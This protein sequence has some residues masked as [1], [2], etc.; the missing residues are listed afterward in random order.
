MIPMY[1]AKENSPATTLAV[2]ISSS[3]TTIRLVN[4]SV[5]PQAPNIFTISPGSDDS[6]TVRY[7]NNPMNNV[8]TVE[9]GFQGTAR[10]WNAGED[11]C[12]VYTAY[13]HDAFIQNIMSL[14]T[15][16]DDTISNITRSGRYISSL[17]KGNKT[18]TFHRDSS[19]KI[20]SWEVSE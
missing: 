14:D 8:V 7:T 18:Y 1:N 13:D 9:R 12:R 19:G 10:S 17:T 15:N 3:T 2:A 11:V 16:E 4:A 5:L 20:E 6:E